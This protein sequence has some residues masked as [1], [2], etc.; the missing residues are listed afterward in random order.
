ML[1]RIKSK[2]RNIVLSIFAMLIPIYAQ[3]VECVDSIDKVVEGEAS[4]EI[5]TFRARQLIL[6]ASLMAVGAV[7]V[8]NGYLR[9]VGRSVR[10]GMNRL[11]GNHYCHV[12]DWVQYLPAV[13]Y[14]GAGCVG[15]EAKHSF[16]ERVAVGVTSYVAMTA[17][18][19][20]GK[21]TIKEKRPDSESRNSFPSGHTA[22][23]FT[24]AELLRQ[25]YGI[26]VGIAGYTVATGV[27]FLRL[28][29][30][31][32]WLNDVVAGAGVGIMSARI[33]YWM[34]PVYRKW[35]GWYN[36][37]SRQILAMFPAYNQYSGSVGVSAVY[38]F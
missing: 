4:V 13:A 15:A 16:R 24:G 10:D 19:N 29:N 8:Y 14:L 38:I 25:E 34:L 20:V 5:E 32:H 23:V 26:G 1:A 11:R 35:F 36:N 27:A 17:I 7:G 9:H 37:K 2:A 33:G 31:R 28:Y 3:G 18:V 30:G 12:D 6:P 21:Y 22:T